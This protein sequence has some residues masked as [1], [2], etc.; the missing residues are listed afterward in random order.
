MTSDVEELQAR[1]ARYPAQ[2][3]PAQHATTQ[4]RLGA[5]LLET[6]DVDRAVGSVTAAERIFSDLGM[7]VEQARS[8]MMLGA[9]LRAADRP[10]EALARFAAAAEIFADLGHQAEEAAA[11]HNRGLVLADTGDPDG[12]CA[13]FA[14]AARLFRVAGEPVWAGTAE[15][16]HGGVLLRAGHPT[17]A[18]PLL[19]S[20]VADLGPAHPG[21]AG[22][23][24]N[25]L[26]LALVAAGEPAAAVDVLR[27]AL[28][29]HPRSVRPADHAMV[30]ANL[31]LS[32][33]AAGAPAHARLAAR[34][35]G[36]VPEAAEPVRVLAGA[37]LDR[38][39]AAHGSDLVAVL[40]VDPPARGAAWVREELLCWTDLAE[41]DAV[42]LA[43][44]WISGQAA[45]GA[46][47][48][49][50]AELLLDGLLELPPATYER[51]VE[52]LVR[53]A[54]EVGEAAAASFQRVTGS[55]MARFP[56]PQWQ[57]ME[58]TFRAAAEHTGVGLLWT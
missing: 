11:H 28:G 14:T 12:A 4:F 32:H 39:P 44:A 33:E 10:G 58:A 25:T 48:V 9:G 15:R 52:L 13:A 3:Y 27:Q 49:R 17:E 21:G 40:A 24:A 43:A 26:G 55:A 36:A 31:A 5:V 16:E 29:W 7:R 41:P 8:A 1:L 34:H 35:A 38:L 20:A 18:V 23:A 2:R 50:Y 45:G 51:V 37:V 57:R 22:A 54:A 42:A 19:R 46:E 56:L 47:G 30:K 6:G 53:A